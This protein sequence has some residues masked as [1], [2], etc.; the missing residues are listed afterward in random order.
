MSITKVNKGLMDGGFVPD[1]LLGC[2]ISAFAVDTYVPTGCVPAN[3]G[4]YTRTQF[5]SLYD[6][7]LV[8]GKLL[9]CTYA[10]QTAQVALTGN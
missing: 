2:I 8:G 4:E 7:Y 3:G 9:T 10:E 5:P 6:N 1:A